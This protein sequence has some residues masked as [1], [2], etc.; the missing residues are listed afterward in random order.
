MVRPENFNRPKISRAI[1]QRVTRQP[2]FK[3]RPSH[4]GFVVDKAELGHGFF[5]LLRFLLPIPIL[6]SASLS[7]RDGTLGQIVADVGF[8]L[9]PP[10]ETKKLTKPILRNGRRSRPSYIDALKWYRC[11]TQYT[12]S[13][14][15]MEKL[16]ERKQGNKAAFIVTHCG[17]CQRCLSEVDF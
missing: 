13:R 17:C 15:N 9:T 7:Y 5:L 14:C 11:L 1:V 6:P 4:V 12:V 10:H 16:K 2:G 8:S 3:P